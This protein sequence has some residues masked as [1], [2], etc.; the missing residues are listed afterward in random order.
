MSGD[1]VGPATAPGDLQ[2]NV[3][4]TMSSGCYAKRIYLPFL[5][6]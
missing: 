2:A 5:A 4:F 6:K 1:G 3:R